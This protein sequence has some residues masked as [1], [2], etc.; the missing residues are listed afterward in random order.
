MMEERD[1]A[2]QALFDDAQRGL[3]D[4]EFIKSVMARTISL[5]YRLLATGL[6][7]IAFLLVSAVL[8]SVPL[9]DFAYVVTELLSTELVLISNV[10]AAWILTP[11]NNI[12]TLLVV[13][14]KIVKTGISRA[15]QASYA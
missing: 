6:G 12:A 5:K 2:I 1:P 9:I 15:R 11:I 13:I 14:G 4:D 10:T 3:H 8:F 7:L